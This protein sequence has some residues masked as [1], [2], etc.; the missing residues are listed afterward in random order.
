MSVETGLGNEY[1]YRTHSA[2]CEGELGGGEKLA[3]R[4]ARGQLARHSLLTRDE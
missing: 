2:S 1:T 3:L 4:L